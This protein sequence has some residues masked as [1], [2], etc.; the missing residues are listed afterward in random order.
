[1]MSR[2]IPP[3]R[4]VSEEVSSAEKISSLTLRVGVAGSRGE[5]INAARLTTFLLL[6]GVGLRLFHYLREPSI[7]HDEAALLLNVIGKNFHEL[8]GPLLFAE[9]APP[10]FLWVERGVYLTLGPGIQALRLVPF[11]ASCVSLL[12]F[13]F[14]A[15]RLLRPS[16]VP[17]AVLLFA[18]SDHLLWHTCE[19]KP[20]SV[21]VL[22]AAL[23]LAVYCATRTWSLGWQL[24][25]YMALTP[26]LMGVSYPGCFLCGGLLIALLPAVGRAR[27]WRTSMGY[28]LLALIVT[29]TFLVLVLGPADAQ[30]SDLMARCWERQFPCWHRPWSVPAWMVLS[31]LEVVRYCCAPTGPFLAAIAV[32]GTVSLWGQGQRAIV[33]LL[34]VPIVLALFASCLGAYPYGGVRVLVYAAPALILLI[35]AGLPGAFA[36]LRA[37]SRLA[38]LALAGL[39]LA[40]AG[41]TGYRL[42]VPW[43]RADCASAAGYV[44]GHRQPT[45][46]VTCNHWEYLYY[47]QHLGPVTGFG[48]CYPGRR[49][50]TGERSS[51]PCRPMI[52][53]HLSNAILPEPACSCSTAIPRLFRPAATMSERP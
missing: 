22:S 16:A 47:F 25:L 23:L 40:P 33:A 5:S 12:L 21:D 1:M 50:K 6:L 31:S 7:W 36:W 18:C 11:L 15:R 24:L 10:L 3:T 43:Q 53:V 35:A 29:G 32:L 52:G 19:A 44:L 34:T 46:G 49:R 14:S 2:I 17:W 37:R 9:A 27:H 13:A 45:D 8:L 42:V 39:L 48:S 20:Y 41:L 26:L 28:G 30:R 51:G 38:T 4:S